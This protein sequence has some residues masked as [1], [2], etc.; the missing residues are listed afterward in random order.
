MVQ[1]I[2]FIFLIFFSSR[3]IDYDLSYVKPLIGK[4]LLQ[5]NNFF[6]L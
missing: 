5:R 6:Y 3:N 1:K 4:G 2:V